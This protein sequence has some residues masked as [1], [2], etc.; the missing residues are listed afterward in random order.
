MGGDDAAVTCEAPTLRPRGA[1]CEADLQNSVAVCAVTVYWL[2]VLKPG[3]CYRG[4]TLR[5]SGAAKHIPAHQTRF[6][7]ITGAN[8]ALWVGSP[9][10]GGRGC[11]LPHPGFPGVVRVDVP[12]TRSGCG[13]C[14]HEHL[15]LAVRM[16]LGH[17]A[18]RG[19]NLAALYNE[20]PKLGA[21]SEFT[22]VRDVA[23]SR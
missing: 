5:C 8:V 20:T 18:N 12:T 22:S 3:L 2:D 13:D 1:P 7:G 17:R 15:L 14:C 10:P 16:V 23:P 11:E 21:R 9:P 4:A 19:H 6:H